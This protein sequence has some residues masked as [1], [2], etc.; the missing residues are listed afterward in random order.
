MYLSSSVII[1]EMISEMHTME[2]YGSLKPISH[3]QIIEFR[4]ECV[5]LY[6]KQRFQFPFCLDSYTDD[7]IARKPWI[8]RHKD[9][10]EEPQQTF[11]HGTTNNMLTV[12]PDPDPQS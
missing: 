10:T 6:G 5:N 8:Y 7:L 9:N 12:L 11:L 3:S 1:S 2:K 4:V